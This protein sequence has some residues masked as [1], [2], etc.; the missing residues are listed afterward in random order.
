MSPNNTQSSRAFLILAVLGIFLSV[1]VIVYSGF[2]PERV[3]DESQQ[4][5]LIPPPAD[6]SPEVLAAYEAK[7]K[8]F[9]K[10]SSTLR[11]GVECA[12]D[13]LALKFKAGR[14]LNITNNDTKEHTVAF[15]D[16]NFFNVSPGATRVINI[17]KTFTK[18]AGIYRYRC[19][20]LSLTANVGLMYVVQ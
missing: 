1:G 6:A 12:I 14:E 2:S 7:V 3:G 20:D 13:P 4:A 18:G 10:E 11:V 19:S 15:E 9:A 17:T 16:Q 8:L 5:L